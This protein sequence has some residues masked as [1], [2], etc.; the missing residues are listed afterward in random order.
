MNLSLQDVFLAEYPQ[1]N[2]IREAFCPYRVCPIGAHSDHQYG[3]VSGFAI[4]Q[5]IKMLYT[6]TENGVIELSSRNFTGK[7]QFHIHD[8]PKKQ[9]DWADY[10]R[11][12]AMALGI[13]HELHRGIYGVIEGSLPVGG[14]S[15]S[16]AVIICFLAALCRANKIALTAHEMIE[17]ALWA[18]M[19]YVGINV[20]KLDQSCEVYSRK[21]NLLFL[22]T[23]DDTYELIPQ[24]PNMAPY[25]FAI[26]FSGVERTLV[27][28]KFNMRVDELKAA[29]YALKGFAKMEY[30]RFA[31]SRLRD[32][33]R[34]VFDKYASRLPENWFK[35][36]THF[37]TEFERVQKGA[38]A[39]RSGDIAAF[40]RLSSESGYSS[41][42]N[43]ETGSDEL[44]ALYDI[45]LKADGVYG[46]RFSGAGF[47]GCVMAIIDPAYETSINSYV[48]REYLKLFPALDGKFS[49]HFCHS[50]DGVK[51][52]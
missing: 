44:K 37:Y 11:G 43:Y 33:P 46:G 8:I 22:D 7:V 47:K 15:S 24:H 6:V 41:I 32:V 36:A 12:A 14:L 10:L 17:T 2:D 25:E 38:E 48:S 50:S 30:G 27:G 29:S 23:R 51:L 4:D 19:H 26:F 35:R 28:S 49:V 18:E 45:M 3:L 52:Y 9:L 40:G 39:W 16:A 20:G 21:D 1:A 5:G 42:Y 34:E 31:D 13:K